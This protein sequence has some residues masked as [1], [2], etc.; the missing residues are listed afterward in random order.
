MIKRT[1]SIKL[2][3]THEQAMALSALA[4]TY[5]KACNAIVPLAVE[6]RCWNRVALHHLSYY[7]VREKLPELGSQMVCQAVHRVA[8]AYK[9]LKANKGIAKDKPV[10]SISFTPSSVNFDK[11]TYSINGETLSLFTL[12]GRAKIPFVCGKHQR[13]LLVSGT[14][15]EA[16]LVVRKGV[17]YF[18]LVLDLPD[19]TPVSGGGALGIDVGENNI[20]ASST[21]KVWGGGKLRHDRDIY[22][23]HRRRLQSNG[24]RAAK[25]KLR[26]ISGREQRHVKHVNHEVSKSIV[27]E[28]IRSGASEIRMEDLTNIRANIKAGKRVRARLHGWAFRQLQDFVAY[29]AEASGLSVVFVNPAY[30]SQTCSVCGE[31]GKR[32]KHSF[33]CSC[34]TRR[35]SDVNAALNMAGFAKPIG[36]A[37]GGKVTRPKFAH[38]GLHDVVES[39]VL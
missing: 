38:R 19:A 23:A 14:P 37:R 17:W 30:T 39:P 36:I 16:K 11:R 5:A 9:T 27:A 1:V 10:P 22:L 33:S 34:G 28:A 3:A 13:N 2:I 21:G 32:V 24:S 15:K 4:D 31:L 18:N 25:R 29:K 8:D 26:A 7:P 20:A 12:G 6:H 35:H